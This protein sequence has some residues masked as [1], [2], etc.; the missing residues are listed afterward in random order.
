MLPTLVLFVLNGWN[1]L[2]LLSVLP[3]S[4]A[5]ATML[6]Q[7]Q[8]E[9]NRLV[10]LL[11]SGLNL[12]GLL[13]ALRACLDPPRTSGLPTFRVR[14]PARLSAEDSGT[15]HHVQVYCT[16]EMA[17]HVGPSAAAVLVAWPSHGAVYP[18]AQFQPG[19]LRRRRSAAMPAGPWRPIPVVITMDEEPSVPTRLLAALYLPDDGL[20]PC[21]SFPAGVS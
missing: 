13:A 1:L 3:P 18:S 8:A 14:W 21:P 15:V 7:Q 20:Q 11:W 6:S 5:M 16:R 2:R 4:P 12:V 19:F 17:G 10:G 9:G